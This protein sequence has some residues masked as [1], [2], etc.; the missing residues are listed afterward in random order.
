M[1]MGWEDSLYTGIFTRLGRVAPRPHDPDVRAWSGTLA[2]WGARS[3]ELPVGGAGWDDDGAL[4]ATIG[5]GIERLEPCRLPGDQAVESS[6]DDWKLDEPPVEPE[7]WV[8]F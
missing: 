2:P 4:Q 3:E 6:F 7:L 5:E 8:L 1:V